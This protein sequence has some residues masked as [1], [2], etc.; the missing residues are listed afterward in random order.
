MVSRGT[1]NFLSLS[2]ERERERERRAHN[3]SHQHKNYY[4]DAH[5]MHAEAECI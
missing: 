2:I 4:V 5:R 1:I 3:K